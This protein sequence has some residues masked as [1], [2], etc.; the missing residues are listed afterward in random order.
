MVQM[1]P[2]CQAP[3][4]SISNRTPDPDKK[5]LNQG[6]PVNPPAG[7]TVGPVS[8]FNLTVPTAQV[9]EVAATQH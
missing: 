7:G 3:P 8:L 2:S 1:M 9:T 5:T 4:I 6:S